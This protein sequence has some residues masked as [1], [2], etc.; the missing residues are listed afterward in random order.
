MIEEKIN[1]SKEE[2]SK[3]ADEIIRQR[4]QEIAGD[5]DVIETNDGSVSIGS[6]TGVNVD[7]PIDNKSEKIVDADNEKLGLSGFSSLSESENKD[8]KIAKDTEEY[9][10]PNELKMA[11]QLELDNINKEPAEDKSIENKKSYQDRDEESQVEDKAL[12]F[13]K[14]ME[15]AGLS[16]DSA[17]DLILQLTDSGRISEEVSLFNGRIKCQLES[18]KMIDSSSFI[19]L[20]DEEDMKTTAKVEFYLNLFSMA[21]ILI[22][23]NGNNIKE[24]SLK[25]RVEWI[26]TNIPTVIYKVLLPK[27]QKFHLKIELLSSEEVANFF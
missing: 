13:E 2:A 12:F 26:E 22:E 15:D 21:A 25:Q 17:I 14:Q 19:D 23:Y 5:G 10:N 16:K 11:S 8:K 20:I 18:P 9:E 6:G 3:A 1:I 4:L 24:L 27:I 7:T